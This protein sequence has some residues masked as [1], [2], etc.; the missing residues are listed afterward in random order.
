MDT[1]GNPDWTAQATDILNRTL[2]DRPNVLAEARSAQ[3]NLPTGVRAGVRAAACAGTPAANATRRAE[4]LRRIALELEIVDQIDFQT[5]WWP[6]DPTPAPAPDPL[7]DV[8]RSRIAA[9]RAKRERKNN[10]R[11]GAA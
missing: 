2:R 11:R 1:S 6:T 10:R 5:A 7:D 4:A 8:A 3:L 9:A